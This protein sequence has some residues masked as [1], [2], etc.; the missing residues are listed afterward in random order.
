MIKRFLVIVFLFTLVLEAQPKYSEISGMAGSFSRMGFGSR[1]IGMGNALSA[2]TTG[3][4]STYYN[5][6]LA[7]FQVDNSFQT[8]YSFLS[9]DRTLNFVNFTK[10]FEMGRNRTDTTKTR[11]VA[12]LSAGLINAGVSKIELRDGQGNKY[13]E[14]STSENLI[15][16]SL[17]NQFSSK[18]AIGLTFRFYYFS[19]VDELS[20]SSLGF[21][22]GAL[23]T[24]SE[25]IKI[26]LVLSD[27]N[28]KYKW[29]TGALYGANGKNTDNKFPLS[30]KIGIS[31]SLPEYKLV[32][33]LEI[34]NYNSTAT[35]I[36]A[37]AE[38]FIIEE[39]ALRGGIDKMNMSN[40]DFPMRPSFG[41]S[42]FYKLSKL[43]I[44][45]D[46]A[47]AIEPYSTHDQH[48]LGIN[49]KF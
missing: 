25:R 31:Y 7:V 48:I 44:G 34:E 42:Y 15:Y 14:V 5:P 32:T 33:A 23:Y 1:G 16:V 6:A 46:Y 26:S 45:V 13:D 47:F 12:G 39:F 10:R 20:A 27:I 3:H 30:K 29:D 38:Y 11:S 17:A 43:V 22:I 2:V 35:F 41:F 21:D 40:G 36:R 49:F 24:L 9:L 18:L 8:S 19:L 37:G 4:L 28:S